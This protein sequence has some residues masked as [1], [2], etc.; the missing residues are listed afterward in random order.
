M[1]VQ[2]RPPSVVR[3]TPRSPPCG[4]AGEPRPA[5]EPCAA[6]N[7]VFASRGSTMT[8]PMYCDERR[9]ML[10]H[11][12]PPSTLLYMPLPGVN[13]QPDRLPVPTYTVPGCDGATATAPI[14]G[15]CISSKIGSHV[16]P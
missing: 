16:V 8:A 5:A 3:Y 13:D 2:V 12:R 10:V 1:R 6:T 4:G 7:T 15:T 9:P 14:D 11:V